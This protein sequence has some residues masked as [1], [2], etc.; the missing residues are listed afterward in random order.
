MNTKNTMPFNGLVKL[1]EECG[2]LL[3]VAAKKMAYFGTDDHPDGKGSMLRRMEDEISDV[4]ASC[5]YVMRKFDMDIE[6]MAERSANKIALYEK[7]ETD[8]E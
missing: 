7:W 3:Q 2:E 4:M 5:L 8:T 1:S 6:Y